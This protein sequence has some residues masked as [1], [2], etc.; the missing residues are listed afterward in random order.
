MLT[1]IE[2]GHGGV[3]L[4]REELDKIACWIDLYV[5]YC[6]DYEEAGAWTPEETAKYRR[7]L[8]KRRKMEALEQR[9]IEELLASQEQATPTRIP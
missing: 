8:E 6:G 4:N 7:Y 1:L 2:G 9:N 5:P 3:R